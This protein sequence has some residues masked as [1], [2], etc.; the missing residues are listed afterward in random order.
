MVSLG[1]APKRPVSS[2]LVLENSCFNGPGTGLLMSIA[3]SLSFCK[4][5]GNDRNK[6]DWKWTQ[7]E[8]VWLQSGEQREAQQRFRLN[9]RLNYS[10]WSSVYCAIALRGERP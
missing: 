1:A 9:G 7:A 4:N 3:L 10:F 5:D 8:V 6:E 2:H